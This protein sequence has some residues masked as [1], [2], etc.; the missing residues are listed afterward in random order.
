[1]EQAILVYLDLEGSPI[2]V[3]ELWARYRNGRESMSFEYDRS[4]LNHPSRFSLDP[5]LQLVEGA[6]HTSSDKPL[7]GSI[8]DSAPDRWGRSLMRRAERKNAEKEKRMP[9][10]LREIDFLLMVD[11]EGRQGALRFKREEQGPFLTVYHKNHIPPLVSVG[12]LLTAA[13]H[14]LQESDTEEDLRLLLAPGSSLGGARPKASV[15]DTDGHLAIAKFPRKDDEID[16]IGW[17]AVALALAEKAGIKVPEWRLEPVGRTRILLSRRFDRKKNV[18]IPFLSAMS[19]LQ[20]KD[21][22]MHSYLEI[23][24]AIRIMSGSPAEDLEILWRCIVFNVLISNVDDHLRNH[25][26]LYGGLSGWHLAPAYDLNPTPTDIKPR[27]LSTA[28]DLIDATASIDLALGVAEYFGIKSAQAKKI[29]REVGSATGLWNKEA[30]KF[31]IKKIE[32]DR[33]ASAFEHEDS[34][35]YNLN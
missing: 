26:F 12:K 17:E 8:D 13:N 27:V 11:D 14:V 21:N 30:A 3:G 5:A 31:K 4:W 34:Q 33:M 22:E 16:V 25:A 10:A 18:R 29:I 9:R 6:F 28:I 23:A 2:K 24:D 32:I 15:M 7:F 20:A 1:M 19:V 35:S